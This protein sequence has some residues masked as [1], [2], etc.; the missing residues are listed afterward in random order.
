MKIAC[1]RCGA[2]VTFDPATGKCFCEYCGSLSDIKEFELNQYEDA[3]Q[4][5]NSHV[6]M[7]AQAQEQ[8]KP[9]DGTYESAEQQDMTDNYDEFHCS[10]CGAKL[11]TDKLTTITR[12]VFCGSQQMIK[13]RMT[14]KFEPKEIIPFKI[15]K[16]D[17]ISRYTS[18]VN[19]KFFAPEEFRKNPAITETRGLYVP[20]HFFECGVT[21]YGRGLGQYHSNKTTYS[22]WFEYKVDDEVLIPIDGS[23][24]LDD[25]IMASLEPYSFNEL[26]KFNPAYI[27]G[28]QSECSDE[29][30]ESLKNKA[31]NRA[32]SHS[33][34]TIEKKLGRYRH[35]AGYLASDVKNMQKDSKYVLLPVWFLNTNFKNKKYS[36]AINGQNGKVVGEI[37]LSKPKFYPFMTLLVLIALV[38]TLF[39]IVGSSGGSSRR[40][41]SSNDGKGKIIGCIWIFG[42]ATPYISI[43]KKY[44]NISHVLEKPIPFRNRKVVK[45]VEY[46][47]KK[48]YEADFP[49]DTLKDLRYQKYEEGK[50]VK[51][52][53][54][55]QLEKEIASIDKNEISVN[56][57]NL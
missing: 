39:I 5:A 2:D 48:E 55:N 19:K 57:Q 50:Y 47:R 8:T 41:S 43:K 21:S 4:K 22:K 29:T 9:G 15:S 10:S 20:F 35:V 52:I 24:R 11:I 46:K 31:K 13:Q 18:F 28:F 30:D 17:F 25:S 1:P 56:N 45:D 12:C 54:I 16:A 34:T 26:T 33:I 6:G 44:K 40:S 38:L 14:G 32:L 36:Y 27:T 23:T 42:V 53:D 3:K 37:P 51:D 7:Q 49:N